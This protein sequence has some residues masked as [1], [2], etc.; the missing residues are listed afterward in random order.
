MAHSWVVGDAQQGLME[1][2]AST[3]LHPLLP[4]L[5][6]GL[7]LIAGRALVL[8]GFVQVLGSYGRNLWMSLSH[9]SAAYLPP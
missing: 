5:L 1:H 8:G 4:G 2:L 6:L 7:H 9:E 3:L